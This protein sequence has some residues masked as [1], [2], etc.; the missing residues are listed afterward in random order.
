MHVPGII[1]ILVQSIPYL[2]SETT[3]FFISC[4]LLKNKTEK[5]FVG[6]MLYYSKRCLRQE[7]TVLLHADI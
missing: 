2:V 1:Y 4:Q 6:F 5:R 7:A 3:F